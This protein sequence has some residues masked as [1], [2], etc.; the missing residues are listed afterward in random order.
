MRTIDSVHDLSQ[1][2]LSLMADIDH[3]IGMRG[4]YDRYGNSPTAI[5]TSIRELRRILLELGNE[6]DANE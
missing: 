3:R 2:G 4:A 1:L 6:V 5:K